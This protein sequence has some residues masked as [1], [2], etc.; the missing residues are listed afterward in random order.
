MAAYLSAPREVFP[1]RSLD[2]VAQAYLPGTGSTVIKKAVSYLKRLIMDK[3]ILRSSVRLK[4]GEGK[5]PVTRAAVLQEVKGKLPLDE[6]VAVYKC[7]E[8]RDWY[9]T[10]TRVETAIKLS[11]E[12]FRSNTGVTVKIE[13]LD[14][15]RVR[16]RVHWFPFH[17][18]GEL[19]EEYMEDYG[20]QVNIEYETQSHDGVNMKTGTISGTMV[21][22][23]S[24]FQ[25]IPYR[26]HIRGRLV[27]ITVMGRQT[28][29]LRC[30]EKGHQRS[31]CPLKT[32]QAQKSYAAAARGE[33]DDWQT[34]GRNGKSKPVEKTVEEHVPLSPESEVGA[35]GEHV[36]L[37]PESE[38]GATKEHVPLSRESEVGDKM[39]PPQDRRGRG[40]EEEEGSTLPPLQDKRRS[41]NVSDG[42][43][44][45]DAMDTSK[46]ERNRKR[47]KATD[48]TVKKKAKDN[49]NDNDILDLASDVKP[50][51]SI[52]LTPPSN[53]IISIEI[54]NDKEK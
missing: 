15:R 12:T 13:S 45:E 29:C 28:V 25:S 5:Y 14:R 1:T 44:E 52:G 11:D 39:G 9:L 42:K 35:T 49:V 47:K 40:Q 32:T 31:T 27:L 48:E 30:G 54:D 50:I 43:E 6:L 3:E 8:G 23:E 34:A 37:S 17:M 46:P 10:F 16:F 36:P 41:G 7:G 21:C 18:K 20:S 22:S 38:V 2:D 53:E 4:F 51:L 26:A 19:V 33:Q 24:Q